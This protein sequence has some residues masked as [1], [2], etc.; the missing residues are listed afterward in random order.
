MRWAKQWWRLLIILLAI[1]SV[2]W[3]KEERCQAQAY[4]CRAAYKAQ[5][6]AERP[7]LGLSVDE[8]AFEQQAIAAACESDGYFCR[9]FSS[10]NLPSML[11]V[12]I[13]IGGIW[14]ALRTL[15]AIQKQVDAMV[16]ADR[17]WVVAELIPLAAKY[18]GQ[19]HRFESYGPVAMSDEEIVN[20][21]HLKHKLRLTNMGRTPAHILRYKIDYSREV[22]VTG[23][24]LRMVDTPKR[25]EIEF[26]RLL[27]GDGSVEVGDIDIFQYIRDS[28]LN[29][30]DSK[31][32]GILNGWVEYEHMFSDTDILRIPFVYLY[33]PSDQELRRIPL[34]KPTKGKQE[35]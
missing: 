5:L 32:T 29:I 16:N 33:V 4:Q 18:G 8:Q 22:D 7:S 19:W 30:G 10:A 24:D 28:I 1:A 12:F 35:H 23:P 34:R 2:I 26:D 17:A 15:G 14:A 11:L 6:K 31:A 25:P 13:G 20:G 27:A 9:L 3:W 21:D